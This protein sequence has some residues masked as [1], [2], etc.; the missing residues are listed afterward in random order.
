[1]VVHEQTRELR[2]L[3]CLALQADFFN[4]KGLQLHQRE[5]DLRACL[6]AKEVRLDRRPTGL[7]IDRRPATRRQSDPSAPF[8]LEQQRARRHVLELTRRIIPIPEPR[9]LLADPASVPLRIP[10]N[11]RTHLLDLLL[12]DVASLNDAGCEHFPDVALR[13]P[14]SSEK[15]ALFFSENLDGDPHCEMR[16]SPPSCRSHVNRPE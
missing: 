9:Q 14:E 6:L 1:M 7:A 2:L 10:R 16:S 13:N 3:A 11:Q 8:E 15:S 4:A 12:A 5:A